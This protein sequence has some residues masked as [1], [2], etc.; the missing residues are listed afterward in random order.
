MKKLV[1]AAVSLSLVLAATSGGALAQ[2]GASPVISTNGSG[3]CT[4]SPSIV[5][6]AN[7]GDWSINCGDINKGSG[8][9]VISPPTASSA[10][11]P[12]E[13]A[14]IPEPVA[15]T[16]A[17]PAPVEDV[18]VEAAPIE[19]APVEETVAETPADTAVAEP[20]AAADLDGDNYPDAQEVELGLDPTNIDG[21]GDG[22]ADGDELNIYATDPFTADSD[23]DGISDGGELYDTRTDPLVWTDFSV[24][25]TEPTDQ[26]VEQDPAA[27][28][29]M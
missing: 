9:T 4:V 17:E 10:P 7:S 13:T 22:V 14:P 3:V 26:T 8:L 1:V 11:L 2:S 16:A 25:A 23:G 12:V 20:A 27:Q 15:D 21:D 6:G 5:P 18:P 29:G 19:A 28:D 24:P